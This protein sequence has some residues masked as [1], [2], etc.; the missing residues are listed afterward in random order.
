MNRRELL[1]R[2]ATL[3]VIS[4][5]YLEVGKSFVKEERL[6][7]KMSF[8]SFYLIFMICEDRYLVKKLFG[9][10]GRKY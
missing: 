10:P 8:F 6:G 7:K 5:S 1:D 2:L 4:G 9:F 3:E